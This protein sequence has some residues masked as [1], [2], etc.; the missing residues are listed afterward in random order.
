MIS[1]AMN[2]RS[3]LT[4]WS[5]VERRWGGLLAT[6]WIPAWVFISRFCDAREDAPKLV[7]YLERVGV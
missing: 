4:V 6:F 7:R 2:C 5:R 1:L 3:G